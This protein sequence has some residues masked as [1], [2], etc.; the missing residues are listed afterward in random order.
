M[1]Y[2]LYCR[3]FLQNNGTSNYRRCN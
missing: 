3:S 2:F 1:M